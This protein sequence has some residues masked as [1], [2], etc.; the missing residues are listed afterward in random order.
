MSTLTTNKSIINTGKFKSDGKPKILKIR[1]DVDSLEVRN[2]TQMATTNA[3]G[4]G[5]KFEWQRGMSDDTGIEYKKQAN[6]NAVD[7]V[8][9]TSGGFTLVDTSTDS[10]GGAVAV[11]TTSNAAK[12]VVV[13]ATT[14]GLH[15]GT[16]VRLQSVA[17]AYNMCGMDIEVGAVT[18]ATNFTAAYAFSSARAA[19]TAGTYRII[20]Y[21]N[22]NM[23]QVRYIINV[24][25]AASAVIT[26]SVTHGYSVG[27][28]IKIVMPEEY[29]MVE[30]N[31][32][33]VTVTAVDTAN[34][35]IT[36]DIDSTGFTA[37]DFPVDAALP[38]SPAITVP[39]G[40]ENKIAYIETT[41]YTCSDEGY[42]GIVLDGG[43]QAPTGS[44]DDII[45][46]KSET[47]L[48]N[49]DETT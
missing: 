5:I 46:W 16:I 23:P 21:Q 36:V 9:L 11:T 39:D 49:T 26:M 19:G 45:Y 38:F 43:V 15:V 28:R 3:T 29:D 34:N 27:Q 10:V 41:P 31:N 8:T 6:V 12:P 30:I 17:A 14:T 48:N 20:K 18:P 13:T 4:R 33:Y 7:C 35:T 24:T 32:K 42:L 37:F 1:S 47:S 44:A 22:N 25:Q 2:Y 40:N